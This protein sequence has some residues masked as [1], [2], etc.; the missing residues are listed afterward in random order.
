MR[1][2]NAPHHQDISTFPYHLHDGDK[3]VP[4]ERVFIDEVLAEIHKRFD[5]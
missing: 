3:I 4:S 5:K 2:D 1:W